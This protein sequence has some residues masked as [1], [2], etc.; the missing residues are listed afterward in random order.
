MGC[1]WSV[2]LLEIAHGQTEKERPQIDGRR[3]PRHFKQPESPVEGRFSLVE[4]LDPAARS[5][6]LEKASCRSFSLRRIMKDPAT[7]SILSSR[8]ISVEGRQ[9]CTADRDR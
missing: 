2:D 6:E 9:L 4:N 1:H 5:A 8:L 3:V 7:V